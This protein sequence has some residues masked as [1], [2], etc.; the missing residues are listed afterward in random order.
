MGDEGMTSIFWQQIFFIGSLIG[1]VFIAAALIYLALQVKQYTKATRQNTHI[2]F[3]GK[4]LDFNIALAQHK[5][6]ADVYQRGLRG[7]KG[8]GREEQSQFFSTATF[9]FSYWNEAYRGFQQGML[10]QEH[11]DECR[12]I[13]TDFAQFPGVQ[14]YWE[15]RKHWYSSE[16]QSL[17][18]QLILESYQKAD[19]VYPETLT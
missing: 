13:L 19:P 6:L 3:L 4:F 17:V 12:A 1:F 8:L 9:I 16:L 7:L 11:W 5:E 18:N 2:S 14:E 10:P 15:Y